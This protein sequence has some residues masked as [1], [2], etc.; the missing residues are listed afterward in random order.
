MRPWPLETPWTP[1]GRLTLALLA[2]LGWAAPLAADDLGPGLDLKAGVA[3]PLSPLGHNSFSQ[4]YTSATQPDVALTYRVDPAWQL[5]LELQLAGFNHESVAQTTLST[6]GCGLVG[7]WDFDPEAQ[8]DQDH[9]YAQLGL[10][11]GGAQLR[12]D[13]LYQSRQ[14]TSFCGH[15]TFGWEQPLTGWTSLLAEVR[16][17]LL[18]G[19]GSTDPIATGS[20]S[21]GLRFGFP[22]KDGAAR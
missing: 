7:E 16:A 2:G 10:G 14:W 1:L 12:T 4:A 21:L 17:W 9:L 8:G 22:P 19:P 11:A 15:L 5:G 18:V 13:A 3:V 6:W 20:V